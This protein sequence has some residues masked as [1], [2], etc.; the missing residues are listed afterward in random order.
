MPFTHL[1]P[2]PLKKCFPASRKKLFRAIHMPTRIQDSFPRIRDG[3]EPLGSERGRLCRVLFSLTPATTVVN[4]IN[5]AL[6]FF[7]IPRTLFARAPCSRKI[8]TIA[9]D[10]SVGIARIPENTPQLR[11]SSAQTKDSLCTPFSRCTN[12]QTVGSKRLMTDATM[13]TTQPMAAV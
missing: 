10:P 5:I 4:N 12:G 8:N 7:L 3:I 2:T 9:F 1:M 13:I 11:G 6:F